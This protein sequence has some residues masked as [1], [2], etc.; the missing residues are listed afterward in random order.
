MPNRIIKES[1]RTSKRINELTDFEFRLWLYLIT[2]VDDYGRGSA[3]LDILKGFVFPRIKSITEGDIKNAITVL[4]D[5]DLI[6]LYQINGEL[7]FCF[8][9]W[10]AHQRIQTKQSKF[11][12]PI[13]YLEVEQG[14]AALA[15]E[16]NISRIA[17]D[18]AQNKTMK[19]DMLQDSTVAHGEP[20]L[21]TVI[22]G[23]NPIQSESEYNTNKTFCP[24]PESSVQQKASESAP[25]TKK[26]TV[27]QELV[28]DKGDLIVSLP[29]NT[30]ELYPIYEK[31]IAYYKILYPAIDVLQ[32]LRSML[33]WLNANPTRKKTKSGINRF[34][35]SW[36][37]KSQN[38]AGPNNTKNSN[39]A[40]VKNISNFEQRDNNLDL[41]A[42]EKSKKFL[43]L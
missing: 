24:E 35:N 40:K 37:S 43:G 34:I 28:E 2:Y 22:H 16:N 36:L 21:T 20:P 18:K 14:I 29:L 41:L 25:R 27:K 12:E 10:S 31:D 6:K 8:P 32:E 42:L 11:P 15:Y 30:G 33:G 38:S 9:N 23:L 1:I 19:N 7:F 17:E 39:K 26:G 13:E 4:N 3:E 5:K